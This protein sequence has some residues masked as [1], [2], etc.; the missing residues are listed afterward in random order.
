MRDITSYVP[1]QSHE[2]N[3]AWFGASDTASAATNSAAAQAAV[4]ALG[5]RGGR[6]LVPNQLIDLAEPWVIDVPVVIEGQTGGFAASGVEASGAT[7]R[8]PAGV[9]G[10]KLTSGSRLSEI[11]NL[12][13]R[14]QATVAGNDHGLH[15]L[16]SRCSFANLYVQGFGGH[17]VYLNGG[18][19]DGGNANICFL[20]TIRSVN[21]T[22]DGFRLEGTDANACTLIACDASG[23]LGHGFANLGAKNGFYSPHANGNGASATVTDGVTTMTVDY[24]DQSSSAVWINP[25]SEGGKAFFIDTVSSDNGYLLSVGNYALPTIWSGLSTGTPAKHAASAITVGWVVIDGNEHQRN[26]R[27]GDPAGVKQWRLNAGAANTDQFSLQQNTDALTVFTV[28][29]DASRWTWRDGMD[30]DVGTVTGTKFGINSSRKLGFWGKTPII[31]PASANQAALTNSTGG[32]T[33]GTLSAVSGS[34]ADA[35]INNN[36]AELHKLQNEMRSVLVNLGL[37]KGSA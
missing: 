26:I 24:Y 22:G 35:A 29:A 2:L 6:I 20:S 11:R 14:G 31:Q 7:L 30:I 23:N 3:L 32:T 9:A 18:G 34:G 36:F 33:D 16:A 12:S 1:Q 21:N 19:A 25:Y 27:I 8:W 13:L 17:G 10:I 5:S 28:L 15:V 4:A 37:M